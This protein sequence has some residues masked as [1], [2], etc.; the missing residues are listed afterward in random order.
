MFPQDITKVASSI[1]IFTELE[2]K[3]ADT[4]IHLV[5]LYFWILTFY[6]CGLN[7]PGQKCTERGGGLRDASVVKII[8]CSYRENWI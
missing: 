6:I 7:T 3:E 1:R 2:Q 5:C 8:Y 4:H